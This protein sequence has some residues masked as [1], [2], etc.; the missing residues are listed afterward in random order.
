MQN[1]KKKARKWGFAKAIHDIGLRQK[2]Q[3][4]REIIKTRQDGFEKLKTLSKFYPIIKNN[5][6]NKLHIK[7][8]LIYCD[9]YLILICILKNIYYILN[10][11]TLKIFFF[12]TAIEVKKYGTF[13]TPNET[14]PGKFLNIKII[15][16]KK[17]KYTTCFI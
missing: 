4:E 14:A 5:K 8:I 15:I 11:S 12:F 16:T 2:E 1:K 13:I 9:N 17:L 10:K 6:N 3:E 7:N